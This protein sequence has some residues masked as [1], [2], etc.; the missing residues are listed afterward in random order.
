[1]FA[2]QGVGS[3]FNYYLDNRGRFGGGG[4]G[5]IS[6]ICCNFV[7]SGQAGLPDGCGES[8]TE[9]SAAA[10]TCCPIIRQNI[11]GQGIIYHKINTNRQ[12]FIR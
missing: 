3:G 4:E 8:H 5:D 11:I 12:V 9:L 2:L 1:M 10:G 7:G 6:I